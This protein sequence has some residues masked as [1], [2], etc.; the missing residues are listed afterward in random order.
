[1]GF[2]YRQRVKLLPGVHVNVTAK[3]VSSVSI[4]GRSA[5]VNVGKGMRI[6]GTAGLPG[7]GISYRQLLRPA[8]SGNAPT[9]SLTSNVLLLPDTA[10]A[11]LTPVPRLRPLQPA[12]WS[13]PALKDIEQHIVESQKQRVALEDGI[14]ELNLQE[15]S[16]AYEVARLNK[17][18]RRW[19]HRAKLKAG[20]KQLT[21][22]RAELADAAVLLDEQGSEFE[23]SLPT[24]LRRRYDELSATVS[25]LDNAHAAW[26]VRGSSTIDRVQERTAYGSV[27]DRVPAEWGLA[28]PS[29][30]PRGRARFYDSVPCLRAGE[31]FGL[32]FFPTFVAVERGSSF[33]LV[34]PG[35]ITF[36]LDQ[37]EVVEHQH[38]P[39]GKVSRYTWRYVNKD[40]TP[41]RR[42]NDNPQIPVVDY[43]HLTIS[44]DG[45][46]SETFHFAASPQPVFAPWFALT[47]WFELAAKRGSL[48]DLPRTPVSWS[49]R[50]EADGHYLA[51]SRDGKEVIAF[52]ALKTEG[53][54]VGL[55]GGALGIDFV[56]GSLLTTSPTKLNLWLGE[57]PIELGSFAGHDCRVSS[58]QAAFKVLPPAGQAALDHLVQTLHG[59]VELFLVIDVAG[60]DVCRLRIPADGVQAHLQAIGVPADAMAS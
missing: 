28:W 33:G 15:A 7:T 56:P 55:S 8:S 45:A 58:S 4:G 17:W 37:G 49:L 13:S 25:L 32:Y 44:V 1:M 27:L 46:F 40:G 16:L 18:F 31:A 19:L 14:T 53:L 34:T 11:P 54:W 12:A 50:E 29:F 47:D 10:E 38:V 22:L 30:V 52:A 23:W 43:T 60:V 3:G 5:T 6:V 39:G 51:A 48:N 24:S 36:E 57:E 2:R 26:H 35:D 41:D 9:A 20:R 21:A 42:F 59:E